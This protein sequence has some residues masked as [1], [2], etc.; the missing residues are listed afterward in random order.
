MNSE[1]W[2][3]EEPLRVITCTST[4]C[5]KDL[6]CFRRVRP[7]KGMSYRYGVCFQ[8]GADLIDWDRIDKR[9]LADVDYTFKSLK[10]EMVRHHF[11]HKEIPENVEK[12]ARKT[13]LNGLRIWTSKR[14][15][16]YLKPPVEELFRDGTQ[17]PKTGNIV[18]Y[19][20]YA[21]SSCCRKCMNEWYDIDRARPLTDEEVAYFTELI[22]LY[23]QDRLPTLPEIGESMRKI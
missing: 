9:D 19:A 5:N 21:T 15:E 11:W 16:K 17:T 13:G 1:D 12:K 3:K 7:R 18:Y 4:D 6:H 10:Y 2:R 22:M 14:L 20:Q 23:I 8:C